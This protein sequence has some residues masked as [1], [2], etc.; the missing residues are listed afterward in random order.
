MDGFTKIVLY[1][2]TENPEDPD[3]LPIV[4]GSVPIKGTETGRVVR[5]GHLPLYNV[6]LYRNLADWFESFDN[7]IVY[8]CILEA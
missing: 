8:V 1:G 4:P 5:W 6:S 7:E 3:A 2:S